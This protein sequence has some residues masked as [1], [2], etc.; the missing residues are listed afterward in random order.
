MTDKPKPTTSEYS[1]SR[2]VGHYDERRMFEG[3]RG[4]PG[5]RGPEH[6]L[7]GKAEH[8]TPDRSEEKIR[9]PLD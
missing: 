7:E 4:N 2:T 8:V 5:P 6:Q 3:A 9:R 1:D